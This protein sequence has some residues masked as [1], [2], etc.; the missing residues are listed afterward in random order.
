MRICLSTYVT[1]WLTFNIP[2]K[3]P[4]DYRYTQF[5]KSSKFLDLNCA[6]NKLLKSIKSY[7]EDLSVLRWTKQ[8][9]IESVTIWTVQSERCLRYN[10]NRHSPVTTSMVMP[11]IRWILSDTHHYIQY[12]ITVDTRS[13]EFWYLEFLNSKITF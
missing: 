3:K 12:Y 2:S 8:V 1:Y 6:I 9:K 10:L 13:F 11:P 5:I 4:Y 7:N